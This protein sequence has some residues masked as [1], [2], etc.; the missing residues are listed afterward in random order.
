MIFTLF[1]KNSKIA[2][3][4]PTFTFSEKNTH[5]VLCYIV[6]PVLWNTKLADWQGMHLRLRCLNKLMSHYVIKC[7]SVSSYSYACNLYCVIIDWCWFVCKAPANK[8]TAS[9]CLQSRSL[10]LANRHESVNRHWGQHH[11]HHYHRSSI[12]VSAFLDSITP[13]FKF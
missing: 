13:K 6:L 12:S 1:C 7:W 11:V 3:R 8:Q 5:E 10:G 9:T 4:T 2:E